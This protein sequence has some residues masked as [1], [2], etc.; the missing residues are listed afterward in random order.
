[1]SDLDEPTDIRRLSPVVGTAVLD[2]EIVVFDD[3]QPSLVTLHF[4]KDGTVTYTRRVFG[5]HA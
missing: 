5:R 4:H 1:M 3:C 2:P